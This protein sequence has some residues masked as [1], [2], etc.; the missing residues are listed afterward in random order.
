MQEAHD[1]FI[2]VAHPPYSAQAVKEDLEIA[3]RLHSMKQRH[4]NLAK[5]EKAAY[6]DAFRRWRAR[7]LSLQ[8][9]VLSDTNYWG[10]TGVARGS[11]ETPKAELNTL[12]LAAAEW[13]D[14]EGYSTDTDR[15]S[16]E[17]LCEETVVAQVR[18]SR[19]NL[20]RNM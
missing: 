9:H 7:A 17:A 2:L 11:S 14:V 13:S 1:D 4:L 6:K 19:L 5:Y 8:Q 15:T 18:D 16:V 12:L 10:H 20:M 3:E